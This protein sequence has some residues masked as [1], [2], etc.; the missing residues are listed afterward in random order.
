MQISVIIPFY[1]AKESIIKTLQ[2][3]EKQTLKDNFEVIIIDDGSK[4]GSWERVK[5]LKTS[6]NLKLFH[7]IWD[8]DCNI[9]L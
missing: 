2:A 4:D 9:I 1:N 7:D 3:L 6:L 8:N 5:N